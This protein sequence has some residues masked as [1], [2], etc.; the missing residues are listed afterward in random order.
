MLIV[1]ITWMFTCNS[2][3][4]YRIYLNLGVVCTVGRFSTVWVEFLTTQW[5]LNFCFKRLYQLIQW[6]TYIVGH[7]SYGDIFLVYFQLYCKYWGVGIDLLHV[8]VCV[9]VSYFVRKLSLFLTN[10]CILFLHVGCWSC[11][12]WQW[13]CL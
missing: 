4:S 6:C 2:S 5:F 9:C 11:P 8:C 13:M 7:G 1:S 12:A 3:V 10:F